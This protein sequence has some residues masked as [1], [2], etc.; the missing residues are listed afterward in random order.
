MQ[1]RCVCYSV[2]ALRCLR[3]MCSVSQL[4]ET[5]SWGGGCLR[6]TDTHCVCVMTF[7]RPPDSTR[8]AACRGDCGAVG[9]LSLCALWLEGAGSP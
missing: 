6:K 1:N 9:P 7:R 2:D 3:Q 5:E 4:V 8:V